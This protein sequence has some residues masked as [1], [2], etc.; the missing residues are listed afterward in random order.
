M[1]AARYS[2]YGGPEVIEIVEVDQPVAKD[3]Q[4]LVEVHAAAIN[5]FDWKVRHGYMKEYIPLELPITI[6]ADFAGV[7]VQG[8]A[9]FKE[10]DQV[11]GSAIVLNGGSGAVAE[12]VVANTAN[13]SKQPENVSAQEAAALVLT[14]VSAVQ[15]L[16]QLNLSAGK[17][18]LIHGGAGGIGTAAI[19]YAKHLGAHV[20][21]TVQAKD[22]NYV[23]ELGADQIINYEAERFEDVLQDFDA[24]FDVVGGELYPRSF[25]VLKDG[26]IIISMNEQP[27]EATAKEH[28]VTALYQST[29]VNTDSLNELR[30]LVEAGVIKPKVDREFPLDQAADAFRHLESGH[31]QGKVVITVK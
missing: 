4:V 14:G 13:I 3:D 20:A 24:V 27:D 29:S 9:E 26:G 6:G 5:P 2:E 15:A 25:A 12:F 28:N 19:Q 8:A 11:F 16:N 7:V 31:P 1:K 21:T 23:A 17:K 30:E 22:T 18:V 10:G